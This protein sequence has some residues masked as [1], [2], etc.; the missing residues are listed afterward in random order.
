M[1]DGNAIFEHR[2]IAVVIKNLKLVNYRRFAALT[3]EFPENLIGIIGRNGTGKSTVVEAIGWALY[4]N[5]IARTDKQEIRSQFLQDNSTCTTEIE[6][7]YGQHEYRIV[8][9]LK[10]KNAISEAAIYR[11]GHAE[12]EAVQERGVNEYIESLLKLDYRSFLAS[13]Y[14]RQKD[15]AALSSMQPEERRK[16]IN[17]LIGID[18]IDHARDRVRRDRN[19]KRAFVEGMRTSLKD[20]DVLQQQ[21][22]ELCEVLTTKSAV[23]RGMNDIVSEKSQMLA[24]AKEA[25][26]AQNQKRDL[27]LQWDAHLGKLTSRVREN[28]LARQRA[29]AELSEIAHAEEELTSLSAELDTFEKVKIEKERLDAE[30]TRAA[31]LEGKRKEKTLVENSLAKETIRANDLSPATDESEKF[32]KMLEEIKAK[33]LMLENALA[34]LHEKAKLTAGKK[35]AVKRTGLEAKEKLQRIKELGPDGQCPVCTQTLRDHYE[36]VVMD[37]E[38]Q[39]GDLRTELRSTQEEENTANHGLEL[40]EA[41]LRTLRQQKERLI[42]QHGSAMD[43][44]KNLARAKEAISTFTEQ[45]AVIEKDLLLIGKVSYDEN[46]HKQLRHQFEKSLKLKELAAQLAE[47][48]GRRPKVEGDINRI[49]L[50]IVEIESEIREAKGKQA[51]LGFDDEKYQN[52]KLEVEKKTVALDEAKEELARVKEELAGLR[53]EMDN[54][55]TEIA[56]QKLKREQIEQAAEQVIYLNALDEH[57]GRFRLEL[58]GR[59]RPLIA[60]RASELLSLTTHARYSTVE[61]DEDYNIRIWDGNNPFA[62]E[63]FSGGEQDLANLCLRIAISQVV[64]ERSGGAPINFIVLDEILGSQDAE[65]QTLIMQA[66]AHL[67]SQ[68]R[69]IFLITHIDSIKD[70]LPVIIEVTMEDEQMSSA[71]II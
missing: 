31:K 20:T 48:S 51:A 16:T 65:R 71:K 57:F 49:E 70:L 30:A 25:L 19:E 39:L 56:E 32:E 13:A 4:G 26:E 63:R 12:P 54:L 10:G 50:T 58:A 47:R 60:H 9:Q 41:E 66:L 17:R 45:L 55:D 5:R 40:Q 61:L 42:K 7:V 34:E 1:Q 67:S 36:A 8:R 33:E 18:Q 46:R 23:E 52:S 53:K 43:A 27:H 21:S 15:L 2:R 38:R 22:D 64:A 6:I 14:A 11:D 24:K 37:L 69:Q 44:V 68:F 62:I 59:I 35:E 28:E 29:K 3:L